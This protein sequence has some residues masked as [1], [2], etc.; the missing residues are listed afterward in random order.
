VCVCVDSA[1]FVDVTGAELLAR[2]GAAIQVRRLARRRAMVAD[3]LDAPG[4]C[5]KG[6]LFVFCVHSA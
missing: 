2:H 3:V 5:F 4:A 1:P 6:Q